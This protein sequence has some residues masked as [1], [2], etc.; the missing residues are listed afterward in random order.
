MRTAESE[1]ELPKQLRRPIETPPV[2]RKFSVDQYINLIEGGFFHPEE[3]VELIEGELMNKMGIGKEHAST[4]NRLM[5]LIFRAIANSGYRL[6][7]QN[8]IRLEKSRPEPDLVIQTEASWSSGDDPSAED[9]L[10]IV[11]VSQSS[12]RFDREVKLPIYAKANIPH[13]WIVNLEDGNV[14]VYTK[15]SGGSYE[16]RTIIENN[17]TVSLPQFDV[18]LSISDFI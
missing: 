5:D 1:K 16:E 6:S 15:P 13:F 14:E 9:I 7:I 3:K 12:L 11:E 8:P 2:S 18:S 10:L 17:E 4:V